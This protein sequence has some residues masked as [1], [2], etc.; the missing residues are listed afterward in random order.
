[1]L[2]NHK[3]TTHAWERWNLRFSYLDLST[4][5]DTAKKASK[6]QKEVIKT[7]C[8]SS[9]KEKQNKSV[10]YYISDNSVAFICND[11]MSLIIT[12]IPYVETFKND[13]PTTNKSYREYKHKKRGL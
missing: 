1:M 10:N 12:V 7:H 13:T 8:A 2:F 3:L 5:L 4:E 9:S 6:K 11:D